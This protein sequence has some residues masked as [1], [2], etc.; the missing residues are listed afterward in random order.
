MLLN[1][2]HHL[3]ALLVTS[4]AAPSLSFVYHS[5]K[6]TRIHANS[7][8]TSPSIEEIQQESE[9]LRAEIEVL[10]SE[11]LRRLRALED[12]LVAVPSASLGKKRKSSLIVDAKESGLLPPP[13]PIVIKNTKKKTVGDLLDES[14]WRVSLSE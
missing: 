5:P 7:V 1:L 10:K 8:K 9:V 3:V 2:P 14:I 12:N 6:P 11:A 4:A 13:S